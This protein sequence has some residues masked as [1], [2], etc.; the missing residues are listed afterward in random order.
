MVFFHGPDR[1]PI[2]Q[3]TEIE[4]DKRDLPPRHGGDGSKL[5]S[6]VTP[7]AGPANEG[8]EGNGEDQAE[9]SDGM[10]HAK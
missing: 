6:K 1:K 10:G 2:E 7:L 3:E 8:G 9:Q 5:F 4:I